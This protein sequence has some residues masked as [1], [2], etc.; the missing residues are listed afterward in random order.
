KNWSESLGSAIQRPNH[1]MERTAERS[2]STFEMTST[3][4]LR[5]TRAVVRHRSSCSRQI[6]FPMKTLSRFIAIFSVALVAACAPTNTTLRFKSNREAVAVRNPENP[7]PGDRLE[8]LIGTRKKMFF[9]VTA[10]ASVTSFVSSVA[11]A[12][13]RKDS[14]ATL[15]LDGHLLR[16]FV[17]Q[18]RKPLAISGPPT[19]QN[20]GIISSDPTIS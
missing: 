10:G 8:T 3:L 14:V 5:A 16:I 13:G 4:P 1:A 11:P 19:I 15:S 17:V 9:Y 18:L 6:S 7:K 20:K 12:P 2:A